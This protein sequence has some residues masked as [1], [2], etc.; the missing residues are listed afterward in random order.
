LI[1][2]NDLVAR[3]IQD[4]ERTKKLDLWILGFTVDLF[5]NTLNNFHNSRFTKPGDW[6]AGSYNNPEFD[7][8]GDALFS[9]QDLNECKEIAFKAQELL[10]ND[11][12]YIVLFDT[13]IYE[14]YR[15][16][17]KFPYT[18]AINGLQ[19]VYGLVDSVAVVK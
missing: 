2:F 11:L 7:K 14:V 8:L 19:W 4:P 9:C 1:G 18:E 13:G 10:A 6:N 16:E 17:V 3:V 12:P 5:P 15:S